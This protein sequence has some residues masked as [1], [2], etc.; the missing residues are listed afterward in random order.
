MRQ[1]DKRSGVQHNLF[2]LSLR[3]H[4]LKAAVCAEAY[5]V[6]E[7]IDREAEIAHGLG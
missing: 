1:V 6:D 2:L 7:N 3:I 5:V 4:I